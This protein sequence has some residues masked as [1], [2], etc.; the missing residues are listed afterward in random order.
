M[1]KDTAKKCSHLDE[2]SSECGLSMDL[3]YIL[4]ESRV[5]T[6]KAALLW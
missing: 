1:A 3:K 2:T 4:N 5:L 6:P